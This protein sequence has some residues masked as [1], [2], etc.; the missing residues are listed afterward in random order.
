MKRTIA[1]WG[2]VPE[3]ERIPTLDV[4]RGVAVF[5]ILLANI[6]LFALPGWGTGRWT[7]PEAP[8]ADRHLAFLIGALVEG[9]FYTLFSLLFGMGLALQSDR[10]AARGQPFAGTYLRRLAILLLLGVLHSLLLSAGDILAFYALMGFA[11]LA[12][13]NARPRALLISV[14]VIVGA[15]L[16]CSGLYTGLRPRSPGW[17]APDWQRLAAER[18]AALQQ[19]ASSHP[20]TSTGLAGDERLAH[21]EFM[22]DEECI[23]QS[24]PWRERVRHRA[25]TVFQLGWPARAVFLWWRALPL[26][27]IGICFVRLALFV[28]SRHTTGTYLCLLIVG[29]FSGMVIQGAGLLLPGARLPPAVSSP[30]VLLVFS[31]GAFGLSMSYAAAVALICRSGPGLWLTTPIAVVGRMALTNYLAQSVICGF[32]FYGWGLGLFGRLRPLEAFLLVPVIYVT[33]AV[34]SM[35]WLRYARFGP[36][37]WLWRSL[38][39]GR[40]QPVARR[41]RDAGS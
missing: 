39:Y 7:G 5:G 6:F 26:F 38:T 17:Q 41:P 40:A 35:A 13:R 23:F 15:G 18:Q 2:P 30:L 1:G 27:L 19:G 36:A 8:L 34:F 9:K 16:L 32:L 14:A 10:A 33:Q 29:F 37:E 4:L 24:G 20:G 25:V 22:A 31:A 11:A 21:L 12:F 28:D 3:R